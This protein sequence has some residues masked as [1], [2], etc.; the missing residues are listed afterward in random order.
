MK[1][2]HQLLAWLRRAGVITIMQLALAGR[3]A[4]AAGE[5]FEVGSFNFACPTG[6]QRVA[7]ASSLRAA[8][9][10]VG[11]ATGPFA[12]VVFFQFARGDGGDVPSNIDRWLG[13]FKEAR[14]QIHSKVEARTVGKVKVTYVQ[15]QGTYASGM[16]GHEAAA[17]PDAMLLGAILEGQ[18]GNVF[19]KMTGPLKVV[20]AAA[21]AF[22]RMT[23]QAAQGR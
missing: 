4:S 21:P 12:D 1:T 7:P 14:D 6:W 20:E 8:Q 3:P 22:R 19:V 17:L 10:K 9:L 15:A 13:Q 11:A 5:G 2:K 16:Q 18:S 23:E